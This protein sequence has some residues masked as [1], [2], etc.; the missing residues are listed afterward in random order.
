LFVHIGHL[1][2]QYAVFR[3]KRS[4]ALTAYFTINSAV[5]QFPPLHGYIRNSVFLEKGPI[6]KALRYCVFV[7]PGTR[8]SDIAKAVRF[9]VF[10]NIASTKKL[11]PIS[12]SAVSLIEASIAKIN[13]PVT[14]E[15]L[16]E[17]FL[18]YLSVFSV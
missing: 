14:L 1:P 16:P 10:V 13:P 11:R 12:G 6:A 17:R 5:S 8:K 7:F 2:K 3:A 4:L 18:V 9:C 15:R